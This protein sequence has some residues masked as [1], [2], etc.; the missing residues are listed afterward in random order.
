MNTIEWL[1]KLI[2]FDTISSKS[3]LALISEIQNWFDHYK[4]Q[5][6]LTHDATAKKANL[7]A[8]IADETGQTN[9]GGIIL[10]GHTDVVPVDNQ[11]WE[12]NPFVATKKDE[13]IF[14]RG[15]CDMKGFIATTLALLPKFKKTR[16]KK[17]LH[18]AFSF[19]EEVGC[20]GAPLM[21]NNL[22]QKGFNPSA[23]I[24]GEPTNMQPVV[25]HKGINVFRCNFHG[26]S[27]HSSLT[28][29]G[30]NAIEYAAEL[31]CWLQNLA[32]KLQ[33]SNK[34]DSCF[35]VPF[36][37]LST[38][39]INGGNAMNIIPN[40]CEVIFEFRNL[41]SLT[42]K[43][44][45]EEIHNFIDK[46]LLVNMREKFK[47][48][49]I[50]LDTLATVPA[51]EANEKDEF[52]KTIRLI[53]HELEKIKVAYTTEAGLF[54]QSGIPTIVCGPGSIEQAHRANEYV[55]LEQLQRCE[56][57]LEKLV[58]QVTQ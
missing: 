58:C 8:S 48:A 30:C 32:K 28:P 38:N 42:P 3:N 46:T 29:Q 35:D 52:T 23:C 17:P 27:A 47:D 9:Q 25:A 54:Q 16:L 34:N 21:L 14:G 57:F 51:M 50:T 22:K 1:N 19:D 13:R 41:P 4:V 18:F 24:V 2:S 6:I 20:I 43:Y 26:K 45:I 53:T 39:M 12:T 10:S 37:T 31:I 33:D 40:H 7:F 44:L 15:T 11:N 36:T 55:T 5:S 56:N 49:A